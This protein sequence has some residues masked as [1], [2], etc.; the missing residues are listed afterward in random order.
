MG[1]DGNAVRTAPGSRWCDM[2]VAGFETSAMGD[3]EAEWRAKTWLYRGGQ[4]LPCGCWLQVLV[5]VAVIYGMPY[6]SPSQQEE[7]VC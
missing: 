7:V 6:A 2:E 5:T 1:R 4:C 3:F